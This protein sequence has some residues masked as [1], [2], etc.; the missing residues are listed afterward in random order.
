[1]YD[2]LIFSQHERVDKESITIA[3]CDTLRVQELYL[4]HAIIKPTSLNDDADFVND[5]NGFPNVQ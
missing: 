3:L 4:L 2:K 1:M 5:L